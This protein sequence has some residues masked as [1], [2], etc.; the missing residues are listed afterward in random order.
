MFIKPV[1]E[2][3]EELYRRVVEEALSRRAY[4]VTI[5]SDHTGYGE[6]VETV[7]TGRILSPIASI[8]PLQLIAYHLGRRQELPINTPPGLAKA[9]TT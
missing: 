8:I 7:E 5:T 2:S 1:E 3:A 4:I 9:I 6:V